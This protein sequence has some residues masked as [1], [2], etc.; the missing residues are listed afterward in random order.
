MD[1]RS[2]AD[3]QSAARQALTYVALHSL[4]GAATPD[5]LAAVMRVV[6]STAPAASAPEA[7]G[8]TLN[9]DEIKVRGAGR[10]PLSLVG[11]EVV[12]TATWQ[13]VK[14]HA[15]GRVSVA[16]VAGGRAAKRTPRKRKA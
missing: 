1:H 6:S 5:D 13:V 16:L 3:A 2:L 11:R 15:D 14:E 12:V 9:A 8:L 4:T 7:G 10:R